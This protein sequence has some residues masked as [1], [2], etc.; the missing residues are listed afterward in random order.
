MSRLGDIA[1][2]VR[3]KNAGPFWLTVDI[4]CGSQSVFAQVRTSIT[5]ARIAGV[6]GA[7][8]AVVNRYEMDSL[9]VLKFSFPRPAVQ[10][11]RQ[12]RDMHGASFAALVAEL[13]V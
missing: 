6:F 7:E 3:S 2:K 12:D 4:F 10:G 1:V 9:N 13:E 11:T 8:I 5:S